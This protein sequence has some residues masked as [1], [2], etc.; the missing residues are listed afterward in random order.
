MSICLINTTCSTSALCTST[1]SQ[2]KKTKKA[3]LPHKI[4]LTL[5]YYIIILNSMKRQ[6][7]QKTI[8]QAISS[9]YN[10]KNS[11]YLFKFKLTTR[12]KTG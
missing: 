5:N 3:E 4:E 2:N 7:K 10:P 11:F 8:K 6:Q 9:L 1:N 12:N